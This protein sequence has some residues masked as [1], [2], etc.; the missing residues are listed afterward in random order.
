MGVVHLAVRGAV[1]GVGFRWF[2]R[3]SARALDL[4]G[5][6]RNREDGCVELAVEGEDGKVEQFLSRVERGPAGAVV[7]SVERLPAG[8][9]E[10][11]ARPFTVLR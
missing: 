10:P 1:Q 8:E 11:M 9:L 5:W 2:V 3:E 6:V 7:R 4:A